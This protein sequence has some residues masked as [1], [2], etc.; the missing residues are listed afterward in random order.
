[1]SKI[2]LRKLVEETLDEIYP[3]VKRDLELESKPK[4]VFKETDDNVME[5]MGHIYTEGPTFDIFNRTIVRTESDNEITVDLK[6]LAEMLKSF[7]IMFLRNT[8]KAIVRHLLYHEMRHL[9]QFNTGYK[10]IGTKYDAF[11]IEIFEVPHGFDTFEEDANTFAIAHAKS[12]LEK[13]VSGVIVSH[14]KMPRN[15]LLCEQKYLN[16]FKE[17]YAAAMKTAMHH[18]YNPLVVVSAIVSRYSVNNSKK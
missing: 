2:N 12:G 5:A 11:K 4:L 13:A 17:D 1:M 16:M 15:A 3:E 10:R 9:W 18:S 6:K 7:R 14:Q 8:D